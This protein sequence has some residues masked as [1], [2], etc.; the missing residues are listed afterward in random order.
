MGTNI[1]KASFPFCVSVFKITLTAQ[2][3]NSNQH[4]YARVT[5]L[6]KNIVC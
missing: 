1:F 2:R 4:V 3:C 5:M 6:I